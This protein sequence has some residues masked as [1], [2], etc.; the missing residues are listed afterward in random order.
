MLSFTVSAEIPATK[1][2]IYNA[3]LDSNEHAKMTGDQPAKA[4]EKV[5]DPFTAHDGYV[6][7]KNLELTPSSRIIQSWRTAMFAD[8]EKDSVIEVILEDKKDNTLV[9]IIHTGLPE[10]GMQY[11]QGWTNHYFEPMKKYFATFRKDK[12]VV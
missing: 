5:G 11:Q 3:W 8:T 1:E 10:H 6:T 7:G 9:T 4:S 2:A 12:L